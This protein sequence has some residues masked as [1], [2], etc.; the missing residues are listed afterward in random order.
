MLLCGNKVYNKNNNRDR[1]NDNFTEDLSNLGFNLLLTFDRDKKSYVLK[2]D[3]KSWLYKSKTE[4]WNS[5]VFKYQFKLSDNDIIDLHNPGKVLDVESRL[6]REL[7]LYKYNIRLSGNVIRMSGLSNTATILISSLNGLNKIRS[8]FRRNLGKLKDVDSY[9][10][11][12]GIKA[13]PISYQSE[14]KNE[15]FL[16]N[17]FFTDVKLKHHLKSA[18]NKINNWGWKKNKDDK[19]YLPGIK[20]PQLLLIMESYNNNKYIDLPGGK[21]KPGENCF[22]CMKRE[23]RE[24]TFY[25]FK[26][27]DKIYKTFEIDYMKFFII[28]K[29]N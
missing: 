21:R 8:E 3:K 20:E 12:L 7:N 2:T 29:K 9:E 1:D 23:L 15:R 25:K 14:Q 18:L 17:L 13:V 4:Y 10:N 24:E 19:Y 6:V 11:I 16:K 22:D 28:L 27:K 26:E 5:K